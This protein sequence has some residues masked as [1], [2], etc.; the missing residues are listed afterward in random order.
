MTTRQNKVLVVDD[1]VKHAE[2]GENA[3]NHVLNKRVDIAFLDIDMPGLNGLVLAE[4]L[5]RLKEPPVIIFATAS[6]D[7]AVRGFELQVVDYLL[8]PFQQDRVAE[9]LVRAQRVL[10]EKAGKK[11]HHGEV[12]RVL[13]H[14]LSEVDKLWAERRNGARILVDFN[15]IGWAQAREKEVFV[16]TATEEMKVRLTLNA[17]QE[18]LDS[19][20]FVR[21]HRTWIVNIDL[22]REV[23]PWDS[24][25]MTLIMGDKEKTEIPVSRTYSGA[26]K[27]IT[28]W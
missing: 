4:N 1:E 27:Q 2:N 26:F 15:L 25:S 12:Q 19:A 20:Q 18:R 14:A 7:Y 28:G 11:V 16:R 22:V 6:P 17:L 13:N 3:L 21:V 10:N 9:A 23:I 8:K 24:H 5:L